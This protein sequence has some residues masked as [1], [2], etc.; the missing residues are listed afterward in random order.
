MTTDSERSAHVAIYRERNASGEIE[1][2]VKRLRDWTSPFACHHG[3]VYALADDA[4]TALLSLSQDN[5]R[6]RGALESWE[7]VEKAAKAIYDA[8]NGLDGDHIATIIHENFRVEVR[9]D[10]KGIGD[11]MVVCRAAAR[12]ALETAS[13]ALSPPMTNPQDGV[14]EEM[15][16]KAWEKLDGVLDTE[17]TRQ[18]LRRA[19]EA[20]APALKAQGLREAAD[21]LKYRI[22]KADYDELI[23]LADA[24]DP[25]PEKGNTP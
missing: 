22:K 16:E 5:E 20:I 17:V 25:Q 6:M 2:L 3:A 13:T 18:Y 11:T 21:W 12:A 7:L 8:A 4:A 19:I 15:V 9:D 24:L 14:S 23:A 1:E 10:D